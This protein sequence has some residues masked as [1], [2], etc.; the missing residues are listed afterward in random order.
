MVG[1]TLLVVVFGGAAAFGSIV[2]VNAYNDQQYA[3]LHQGCSSH[4]VSHF[5]TIKDSV[6]SPENTVA[7]KCDT[8]TIKN[9]DDVDRMVAFGV[10]EMHTAYDGVEERDLLGN[11]EFT[12]TLIQTGS[13]KFHDHMHDEV[14]GTF[15]VQ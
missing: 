3:S 4:H 13:F 11:Q 1:I 10:H 9:L 5:V 14:A 2:G 6:V 12:V 7:S 15:Q 8:L